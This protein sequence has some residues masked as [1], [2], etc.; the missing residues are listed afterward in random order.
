MTSEHKTNLRTEL[1]GGLESTIHGIATSIGPILVYLGFFGSQSLAPALWATLITATA[2]PAVGLLFKG[3]PAILPSTRAASLTAYAAL[4]LQLGVASAGPANHGITLSGQ[5]FLT[6]LAAGSLLFALASVLVLLA[7]LFRL[8]NI[9]KMIPSTVTAGISNSTAVLLVWL[10]TKQVL[11]SSWLAAWVA[12]AMVLG[13]TL[14]PR[15]Q[16]Q[17]SVLR[18]FPSMLLAVVVGL[19][20]HVVLVAPLSPVNQELSYDLSWIG[21]G[22][23]P[24]LLLQS[25]LGALLVTGLP[26]AVTLAMVMILE[27]FTANNMLESRFGLR[28]DA[29]RELLVLGGANLASALLGGVPC[30]GAPLR[31]LASRLAGGR[32]VVAAWSSLLL[33][34]V[35]L[36]FVGNWLLVLPAGVMAGLFVLQAPLMVDPAFKNRLFEMLRTRRW[37]RA[38]SGDLGFW[39]TAVISLVGIFGNLIW[40]CF[41]GVGLSC[42]AV[43]R[44]VSGSLTSRWA[45]LGQYRSRR[46]RS[47]SEITLLEQSSREVGIL[48]L[49]GHLFF[50]NSTRLTQL[51]DE[52]H[53]D[54]KSVVLDVSRVHDVDPSG[55]GA[56]VWLIRA[57]VER[58]L[59]VIVTGERQTASEE[60]RQAVLALPGVVLCIDLDRGVEV[61]EDHL[62]KTSAVVPIKLL[63]VRA[64]NNLLLEDIRDDDLTV[65]LMLGEIRQLAQGEALFLQYEDADGVWMLEEGTVSILSGSGDASRLATFGPGQFVGEMGFVDGGSRSATARAD[66]PLQ[67]VFLDNH[68]LA[69]LAQQC[70]GAALK[71]SQNIAREL[72]HRMRNSS[73]RLDHDPQQE[74]A[75]W[76]NSGLPSTFSRF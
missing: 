6:G 73:A 2:V 46:V 24:D 20:V 32:G 62:L 19:V 44:R 52:L 15:L 26:G 5:Q 12:L 70:P 10:A 11:G 54:A 50:G 34:G 69:T 72:S 55:L 61:C 29:S 1:S 59:T 9:F 30:T 56:L 36:L 43:L 64:E 7:G 16:L 67:A 66:T 65:V 49:T 74:T 25:Q 75:G 27:S 31:S 40:A 42:L 57:M 51:L 60:L 17:L 39:I 47:L 45:D 33:T 41:M 58:Q 71:I 35:L 21:V 37:R 3:H 4:V 8:G 22:L 14:W 53:R 68:S 63:S 18:V 13:F 23:W 38:G 48:Q 28:I 76:A